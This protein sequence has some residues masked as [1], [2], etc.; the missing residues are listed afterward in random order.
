MEVRYADPALRDLCASDRELR[1]RFGAD[2]AKK[3]GVRLRA[4]DAAE[5]LDDLMRAPGRCHPLDHEYK[6][7]Y[8]FC[9]HGGMRLVF[10]LLTA[11]ER[12]EQDIPDDSA[13]LVIEIIDYHRG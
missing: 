9:L 8:A 7:C 1:R 3:I 5:S 13:A 12:E 10:R 4:F 2:C 6:G 11:E